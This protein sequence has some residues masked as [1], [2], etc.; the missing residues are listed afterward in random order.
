M[1]RWVARLLSGLVFAATVFFIL[2]WLA[3]T[4]SLPELDGEAS[5]DGLSAV[6][7]IERD[8][9][10]I[11]T[12]T[13]TNRVDL[14]FA[15][16]FAHGQDRFFQIDLIRRQAAGE[17]S[18]IVGAA[19]LETDKRFRFH[20]FRSRAQIALSGLSASESAILKSYAEGV[21]AGLAS[22]DAKPFEY[23]VLRADPQP[24][25]PEDSILV[26]FAMFVMLN[27]SRA[28]RDVQRGLAHRI[29]PAEAFT[30]LYPQGTPWDAPLMGEPRSPIPMPSSDI[31]SI[32]DVKTKSQPANEVGKPNLNGS[33]NWVVG[34]VLTSTG[35]AI[36]SNDMHLGLST[37]NIYY[38]AR[39]VVES[40]EQRDVTG[41]TLP[42][43]PFVV[44]GS[45]GKVAW[46]YTNSYGDWS[47]AILLK[48]G[49]SPDTYQTPDGELPFEAHRE[50][51]E[52]KNSD[53]VELVVRETIW[54]PVLEDIDYPDGD[55]AV[56]WIAH[57]AEA[58][59][60]KLIDLEIA[61]TVYEA[62]DIANTMGIPPQNFVAGDAGGNI[63]WTI[64]GRIP[65]KSS[66]DGMVPSD[67][68][69]EPGWIGWLD[70]SRYP[71]IVNPKSGRIWTANARVTDGEALDLVGDG[72]YDLGARA[73]QIRDRL[74]AKETFVPSDMLGIQYDDRALF[75][76][77]WRELLLD[78]LDKET[79]AADAQLA[80]YRRLVA[81]WIPRA[82]PESVGYRLVRAFRL[83]VQ[84]Q[85]FHA[86]MAPVRDEYAGNLSFRISNQFEASLWTLV[87][88]QPA[89]LLP[90]AYDSWQALMV[91]SVREN[92]RYFE[93][94]FDGPLAERSWGELNTA[95]ITHPLS[96][97]MPMLSSFL[98]MSADPL[99]GDV[100]MPKAQGPTFG[101]SERFSVSPGDE[102][103]GVM[104]M[105][106][107]QS[108]HPL[109][110]FYRHGHEDW[111][112][113]R[114]SPFLPGEAEYRLVLQPSQ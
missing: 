102:A 103:N 1:K 96:P 105:P 62:L 65:Q 79:I 111:V 82:A 26:V 24:W 63:A 97:A 50:N 104:H 51:I 23:F 95:R 70:A 38:Q 92:I 39:L 56:S 85:A 98:D 41:V 18:E 69:E 77:P 30:W 64:A 49:R 43:A 87:T 40:G 2:A 36:V 83:E 106:T 47:D 4:A 19:A 114:A 76:E 99:S 94:N 7:T 21:N 37:P 35:R 53:S 73:R 113:G 15:T 74:F 27:D 54:G 6:A 9:S 55:I 89:H 58:V 45:N 11:P 3:L 5:V 108:G 84:A 33:N 22:L 52:V 61:D 93:E 57:H 46:G 66:F 101:A 42:G 71:R 34:G 29:L 17:L 59:N 72:G 13:A 28:I 107:G 10:G 44:A 91:E 75:L 81:E 90:A 88:E 8:S 12:I 60:L 68:S 48:A 110:D 32:R 80:E 112:K 16:G 25:Q 20:R 31:Y 14:A 78:V 100:D 86:L 109:S 67:W